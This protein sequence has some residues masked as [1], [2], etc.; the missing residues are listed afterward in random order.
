[1]T[2]TFASMQP[3]HPTLYRLGADGQSLDFLFVKCPACGRLAF[4]ANAPGCMHC[5][6]A[7]EQAEQIARPGGGILIEAI[8]L[9]VALVPGMAVPSVVGD[10]QIADDIVEEGVIG[11]ADE[12]A[13]RPGMTL[14]AI[15]VPAASAGSATH[16][17]CHFVPAATG[18]AS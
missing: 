9:H 17:T 6:D 5:G 7:L 4:P 3:L 10:I 18:V 1:M 2:P 16:Y 12:L 8:T 15:A 14:K 13:L 11:V